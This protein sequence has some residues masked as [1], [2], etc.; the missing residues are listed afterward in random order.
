MTKFSE[1]V[2]KE[3]QKKWQPVASVAAK[4]TLTTRG[5][6]H[7]A[8][9]STIQTIQWA[10]D[11]QQYIEKRREAIQKRFFEPSSPDSEKIHESTMKLNTGLPELILTTLSSLYGAKEL[12]VIL[13]QRGL[14]PEL[15]LPLTLL[16][17]GSLLTGNIIRKRNL[18]NAAIYEHQP[19]FIQKL[20]SRIGREQ[21]PSNEY[22]DATLNFHKQEISHILEQLGVDLSSDQMK[23]LLQEDSLKSITSEWLKYYI[24]NPKQETSIYPHIRQLYRL[25]LKTSILILLTEN[26]VISPEEMITFVKTIAQDKKDLP[27]TL[28]AMD[29][30]ELKKK[31]PAIATWS[32]LLTLTTIGLQALQAYFLATHINKPDL[33][34]NLSRFALSYEAFAVGTH[35]LPSVV[36]VMRGITAGL[37]YYL[38]NQTRIYKHTGDDN[39]STSRTSLRVGLLAALPFVGNALAPVAFMN[40]DLGQTLRQTP[41]NDLLRALGSPARKLF[42]AER[43][44][45]SVTIPTIPPIIPENK[46]TPNKAS[47]TPLIVQSLQGPPYRFKLKVPKG[48]TIEDTH[49]SQTDNGEEDLRLDLIQTVYKASGFIEN[50]NENIARERNELDPWGGPS[51]LSYMATVVLVSPEGVKLKVPVGSV[52]RIK[53]IDITQRERVLPAIEFVLKHYHKNGDSKRQKPTREEVYEIAMSLGFTSLLPT[54]VSFLI[55]H[56]ENLTDPQNIPE[57]ISNEL[58]LIKNAREEWSQVVMLKGD[59]NHPKINEISGKL[60]EKLAL[61]AIK[62]I[63]RQQGSIIFTTDNNWF[64]SLMNYFVPK[65]VTQEVVQ[66]L[67]ELA[68][69][70]TI[71]D[72][73]QI[74]KPIVYIINPSLAR[75]YMKSIATKFLARLPG[76]TDIK[77]KIG[78]H[79]PEKAATRLLDLMLMHVTD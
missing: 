61:P 14:N 23:L 25:S 4:T 2:K 40:N 43:N 15:L 54:Q 12:Y 27:A 32:S 24:K 33:I 9:S 53:G 10:K 38:I 58:N 66:Q 77:T 47:D 18:V 31:F 34:G 21:P 56:A 30:E 51:S 67:S 76:P 7:Q 36:G 50:G 3:V 35:V 52:R 57:S 28:H 68:Y 11:P 69:M 71:T 17:A 22:T 39:F 26:G 6:I 64:T 48:W 49:I 59:Q 1:K 20:K 70:P 63:T 16:S 74:Q 13:T 44:A 5:L 42:K 65:T 29:T 62:S 73:H 8:T 55:E 75:P 60:Y 79:I 41:P 72:D 37:L 45:L 78:R 19:T 46:Y